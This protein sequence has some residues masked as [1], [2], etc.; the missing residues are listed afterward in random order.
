MAALVHGQG[1]KTVTGLVDQQDPVP[2]GLAEK[3]DTQ[4]ARCLAV[5]VAAPPR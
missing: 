5:N 1:A 3:I 4:W 2:N